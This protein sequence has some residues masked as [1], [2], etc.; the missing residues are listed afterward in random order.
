MEKLSKKIKIK[1]A[2][3][4]IF[5]ITNLIYKTCKIRFLGEIADEKPTIFLF[6]HGRIAMMAF[7]YK[8]YF[9]HLK[10][11]V[12]ILISNHNDGEIIT[13]TMNIFGIK[14]IRGSSR[15]GAVGAMISALKELKNKNHISITPDG[16]K[17][18][19]HSIADGIINLA[20]KTDVKIAFINY[21]ASLYWQFKSWDKMILPKPFS[22]IN[23]Y[24]SSP[25]SV[26]NLSIDEAKN[27]LLNL[28]KDNEKKCLE[29]KE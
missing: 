25:I 18:P 9:S 2:S 5:I 6:W 24:L 16:P 11:E 8:H 10:N 4:L 29:V 27:R 26:K 28:F 7:S 23:F 17:G 3:F 13:Q 22:R 14:S 12:K 20:Q 21:E 19:F 1:V 15:K